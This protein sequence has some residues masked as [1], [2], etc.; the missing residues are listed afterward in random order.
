MRARDE[1]AQGVG[2]KL[3]TC[4]LLFGGLP[5]KQNDQR[6]QK[7]NL[8]TPQYPGQCAYWVGTLSSGGSLKYEAT[9]V[10]IQKSN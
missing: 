2:Q 1:L 7:L 8:P 10:R 6:I 4:A 3:G 9:S 5:Y